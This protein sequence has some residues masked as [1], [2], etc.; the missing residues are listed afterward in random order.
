MAMRS[1]RRPLLIPLLLLLISACGAR[2]AGAAELLPD[3]VADPPKAVSLSVDAAAGSPALLLRF[4]G[5][6]HNIGPGALDF[7]GT[8]ASTAAPMQSVQRIFRTEDAGW[9]DQPSPADLIFSNAD[10]HNH[11]HLQNAA[12]YSLWNAARS[13]ETAPAQKVGFCLNDSE[14][15]ELDRGPASPVYADD[16]PPYRNFCQQ[17][18]PDAL[19]LFE[20]ISA[21]WRDL[22][23]AGLAF[24]WVDA[25][26]GAARQLLAARGRRPAQPDPRGERGQ[27]GRVGG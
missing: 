8:R 21:G 15:V 25:F 5:Y 12:K 10:G 22:Y 26:D 6:V 16:V 13:A 4:D 27:R 11:W 2:S 23:D 19:S 17:N 24:Q 9:T 3:L 1:L 7:R 18:R 20:G 14:H